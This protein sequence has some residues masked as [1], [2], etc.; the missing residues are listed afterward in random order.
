MTMEDEL[1]Q[2][3]LWGQR[4][5]LIHHAAARVSLAHLRKPDLCGNRAGP[6]TRR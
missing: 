1:T 5:S 3:L 4:N 6:Q 2:E